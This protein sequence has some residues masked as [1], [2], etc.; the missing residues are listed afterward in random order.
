[1]APLTKV[2][3]I[4]AKKSTEE[5]CLMSLKIDAKFKGK[6]TCAFKN[7]FFFYQND[8]HFHIQNYNDDKTKNE[9]YN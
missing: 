8:T 2:Y 3:N 9:E 7:D 5:L 1:M 6:L 4:W